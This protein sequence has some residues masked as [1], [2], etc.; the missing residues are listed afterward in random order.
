M[1][2]GHAGDGNVHVLLFK[3]DLSDELWDKH[4]ALAERELYK[5][6]V[7]LGGRITVEHGIGLL[8]KKYLKMNLGSSQIEV[9]RQLKK[10]FDPKS[11][12]NPGKIFDYV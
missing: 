11:I 10:A 3:E 6:T 1:T 7:D 2:F 9:L 8:R 12:L 4:I 5:E